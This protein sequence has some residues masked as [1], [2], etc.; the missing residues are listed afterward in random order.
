M[1]DKD[2]LAIVKTGF[3]LAAKVDK[4]IEEVTETKNVQVNLDVKTLL[5][6]A[7]PEQLAELSRRALSGGE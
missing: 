3:E 4:K 7:T 5:L 6:G 2:L 1:S